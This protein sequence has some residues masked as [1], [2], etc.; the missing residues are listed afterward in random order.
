[1]IRLNQQLRDA[2]MFQASDLRVNRSGQLSN[3]Q[4]VLLR[5]ARSN[6]NLAMAMFVLV[7]AGTGGF[8]AFTTAQPTGDTSGSQSGNALTSALITVVAIVVVIVIGYLISRKYMTTLSKRQISVAKGKA[9]IASNAENNYHVKIGSTKLRIPSSGQLA[10][11]QPAAEYRVYYIAGPVP[12]ILS[13]E[14]IV[15]G[16]DQDEIALE[17]AEEGPIQQDPVMKLAKGGRT[18]LLVL[19]FMIVQVTAAGLLIGNVQGALRWVLIGALI[20][21]AV[22]F[23]AYALWRLGRD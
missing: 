11:F 3:R 10:A 2:F 14:S 8:I 21:E 9:S 22:G 4:Q 13:G 19:V 18:V 16:V 15:E 1:M 23:A 17:M 5:A 20:V 12:I 7:M 6:T